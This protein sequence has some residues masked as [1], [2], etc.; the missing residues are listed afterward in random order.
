MQIAQDAQAGRGYREVMQGIWESTAAAEPGDA[1]ALAAARF[2]LL[3][4]PHAN[5][6]PPSGAVLNAYLGTC[7]A[8][9]PPFALPS[10]G[11][12]GSGAVRGWSALAA[13][14]CGLGVALGKSGRLEEIRMTILSCLMRYHPEATAELAFGDGSGA[15]AAIDGAGFDAL[16]PLAGAGAASKGGKAVRTR[17]SVEEDAT[18]S[19]SILLVETTDRPGLLTSIVS[20][21]KDVSVNVVSAEVDTEGRIARDEFFVTYHGEPLNPSMTTLVVNALQYYLSQAESA[22]D[23]SY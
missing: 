20:V 9:P 2:L 10:H 13:A 4:P 7:F 21:L 15:G 12:G 22:I 1:G 11:G 18:G 23:E 3:P 8:R 5:D 19:H 17:V 14:G 6:V 16:H